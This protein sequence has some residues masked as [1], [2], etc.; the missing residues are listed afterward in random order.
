MFVFGHI[1]LPL[2]VELDLDLYLTDKNPHY[3]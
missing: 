3:I 1:V 2:I